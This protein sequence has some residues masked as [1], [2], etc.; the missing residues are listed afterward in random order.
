MIS[1]LSFALLVAD[2]LC[3]PDFSG[4]NTG[5]GLNML[6]NVLHTLGAWRPHKRR[7]RGDW[8]SGPQTSDVELIHYII[9]KR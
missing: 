8:D 9:S 1:T 7:A 2:P 6:G 3:F 4:G 5:I